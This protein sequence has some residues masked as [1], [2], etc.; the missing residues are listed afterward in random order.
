MAPVTLKPTVS[1]AQRV[2][3]NF[4]SRVNVAYNVISFQGHLASISEKNPTSMTLP[5]GSIEDLV[6]NFDKILLSDLGEGHGL[7]L[8]YSLCST[9]A[10][11]KPRESALEPSRDSDFPPQRLLFGLRSTVAVYQASLPNIRDSGNFPK[12]EYILDSNDDYFLDP[13]KEKSLSGPA[14]GLVIT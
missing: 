9:P 10:W 5:S 14:Q 2:T 4:N 11:S 7:E 8:K 12:L 6:E 3:F 1:F 13:Q